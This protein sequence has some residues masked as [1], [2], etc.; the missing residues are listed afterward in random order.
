M[1]KESKEK[2]E[3]FYAIGGRVRESLYLGRPIFFLMYYESHM[4]LANLDI[5]LS[6]GVVFLLQEHEDIF[7][8]EIIPRHPPI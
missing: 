4:T 5:S 6:N 8:N 7:L 2:K 3:S 1:Q